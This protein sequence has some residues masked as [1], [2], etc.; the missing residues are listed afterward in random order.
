MAYYGFSDTTMQCYG[1]LWGA[2]GCYGVGL[3]LWEY[4]RFADV[5]FDHFLDIAIIIGLSSLV[6]QVNQKVLDGS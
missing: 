5:M 6:H 3:L 1:V 4:C 2:M